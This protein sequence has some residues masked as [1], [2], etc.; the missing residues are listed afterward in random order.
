MSVYFRHNST[1]SVFDSNSWVVLNA[2][3]KQIKQKIEAVGI[4]LKDWE[5]R[6][7]YG[8]KTGYNDAFII[9]NEKRNELIKKCPKAVDIIRPILRGRDIEPYKGNWAGLYIIYIPWHFPLHKDNS[10]TGVSTKAEKEFEEHY[11]EVYN[12]LLK[13]K[14]QLSERNQSETGIRYEWYA[15]QRWGANYMDDFFKPKIIYPEITKYICFY[16]DSQKNYYV[17][18]KC[19]ILTGECVEY[20]L[21]F[22]NSSLFKYCFINNFP[23]LLGGTR[24]LRKVFL[25]KIPVKKI[26]NK[27]NELFKIK[28]TQ[29]QDLKIQD[30]D[31]RKLEMEIDQL[32]F[33]L[34]E[35]TPGEREAIGFIEI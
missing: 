21:A 23:E 16:F 2:L 11:T 28:I 25:E 17:N 15:L 14:K 13:Y 32:I 30:K 9:T 24:E 10:I 26:T 34:Y 1:I 20:L 18:N 27:Q 22:L 35:L 6:I 33:D 31:T 8:I 19:F 12:H 7:N 4:P 3:E 5:I 29:I